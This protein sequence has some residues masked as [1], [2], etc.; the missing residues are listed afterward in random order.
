MCEGKESYGEKVEKE[1]EEEA[2]MDLG[3]FQPLQLNE[4]FKERMFQQLLSIVV[5]NL[6]WMGNR[7][8]S[9]K[10]DQP[11]ISMMA[12]SQWSSLCW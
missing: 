3:Q 4:R 7:K 9:K 6:E 11:T 1:E 5:N 2:K 12:S 10:K 8:L